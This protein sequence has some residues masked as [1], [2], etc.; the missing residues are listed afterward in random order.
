VHHLC[1]QFDQPNSE[2]QSIEN[3]EIE[4][5]LGKIATSY[6]LF[7]GVYESRALLLCQALTLLLETVAKYDRVPEGSM[8]V[9][10]TL[11]QVPLLPL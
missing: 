2:D 3:D 10:S 1:Q 11:L 5:L 4:H 9:M 6:I 8:L 7:G